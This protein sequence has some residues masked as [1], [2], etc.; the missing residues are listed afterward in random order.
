MSTN[1]PRKTHADLPLE[2]WLEIFRYATYV[3]QAMNI[4]PID[5]FIPDQPSTN[6]LGINTPILSMRT[7]YTRM[8]CVETGY[9]AVTLPI[10]TNQQPRRA[11]PILPSLQGSL[12]IYVT[13]ETIS[14]SY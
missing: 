14:E 9:D 8:L 2:L 5:A 13:G 7:E 6:A 1:S 3:R 12:Q 10:Y 4:T 11:N